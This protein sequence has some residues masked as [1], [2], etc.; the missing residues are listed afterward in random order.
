MQPLAAHFKEEYH[1]KPQND[2]YHGCSGHDPASGDR[3][4]IKVRYT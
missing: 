4:E 3:A 1:E 2:D